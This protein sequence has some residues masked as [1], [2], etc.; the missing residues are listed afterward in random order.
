[1]KPRL[2]DLIWL[3]RVPTF[4]QIVRAIA[5]A[6]NGGL[7]GTGLFDWQRVR[8][9]EIEQSPEGETPPALMADGEYVGRLPVSVAVSSRS[10]RLLVPPAVHRQDA[11]PRGLA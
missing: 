8:S 6:Y 9:I 11:C 1:M 10:M 2:L 3:N 7:L 4:L 5:N